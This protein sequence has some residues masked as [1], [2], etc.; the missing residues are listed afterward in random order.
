[1]KKV[2]SGE[3]KG[4]ITDIDRLRGEGASRTCRWTLDARGLG[5]KKALFCDDLFS[6]HSPVTSPYPSTT[7]FPSMAGQLEPATDDSVRN[8]VVRFHPPRGHRG[9]PARGEWFTSPGLP[10]PTLLRHSAP[11]AAPAR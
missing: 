7:P 3:G 5:V 1:M 10:D 6:L 2:V 8:R 4:G 9:V 11:V